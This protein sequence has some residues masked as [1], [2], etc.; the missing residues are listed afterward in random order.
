[1]KEDNTILHL[2]DYIQN[3][4]KIES[5]NHN[6]ILKVVEKP[7]T[8]LLT[9]TFAF[10]IDLSV[11][12]LLNSMIH[13]AY[14]LFINQFLSPMDESARLTFL[15]TSIT[16]Q[17][18]LFILMFGSYFFYCGVVL[19]GKSLGKKIMRLS[20][21]D[22]RFVIN[23]IENTHEVSIAQ[24]AQRTLGYLL[25][26]VSFGAFFIFNFASEDQRGLSDYLSSTR[27][28]SDEWLDS[29]LE[30][31]EFSAEEVTIDIRSLNKA[32]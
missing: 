11:V 28:V 13:A 22:E 7:D 3:N 9:R 23:H 6:E 17:L 31:K 30:H 2:S 8:N 29:M 15:N 18:S 27:T 16:L 5:V 26:Y 1:M 32:A 14:G 10:G 20:V 24:S 4:R 12:I 25:C 19:S 21:I